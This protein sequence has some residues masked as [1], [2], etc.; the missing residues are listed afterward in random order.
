MRK[1]LFAA[2]LAIALGTG[3][4][5]DAAA[6]A[7][8]ETKVKQRQA[9]M[10]LQGKYFGPLAGMAQGKVPYDASVVARN[11]GYL[12]VITKLAWDSFTPDTANEKTRAL[13][14]IYTDAAGFKAAN[15]KLQAE[16][17]KLVTAA[18]S[19]NEAMAKAA[20]G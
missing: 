16:V 2:G 6:Q 20:I 14:E 8:P 15:E 19:G 9:A 1:T 3:F 18:K 12:E 11:A 13:P 5:L 17:A 4:T 7:K 10:T